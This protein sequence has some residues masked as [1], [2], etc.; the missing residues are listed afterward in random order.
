MSPAD[1][2]AKLFDLSSF[3]GS[4]FVVFGILAT[5]PG[6]IVESWNQ[7][8]DTTGEMYVPGCVAPSCNSTDW[9][10]VTSA[11]V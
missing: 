1:K 9:F 5:I 8:P 10:Q 6:V 3:I 2:L 11:W 4:L 7:G